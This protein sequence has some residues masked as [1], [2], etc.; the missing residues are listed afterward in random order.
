MDRVT[1]TLLSSLAKGIWPVDKVGLVFVTKR[2]TAK[3]PLEQCTE[4]IV[5]DPGAV[6][7]GEGLRIVSFINRYYSYVDWRN[8][9][10]HKSPENKKSEVLVTAFP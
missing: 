4:P 6:N 2:F 1:R 10:T 8:N 9:Y 5:F 3:P 7:W